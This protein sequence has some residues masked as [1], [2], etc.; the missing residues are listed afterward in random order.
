MNPP[1]YIRWEPDDK[2]IVDVM[3]K[4]LREEA[5]RQRTNGLPNTIASSSTGSLLKAARQVADEAAASV[6]ERAS[7]VSPGKF[8]SA[9]LSKLK[10]KDPDMAARRNQ[11][12]SPI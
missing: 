3:E 2:P 7:G 10:A 5:R 12:S 8:S 9:A 6:P 1:V 4:L 11:F